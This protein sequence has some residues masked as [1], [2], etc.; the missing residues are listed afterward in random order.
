M[1]GYNNKYHVGIDGKGYI[2]SQ[3]RPG[4]FYY[5]KKV[6]PSFVNKVGSGDVA[7]RDSTFW[8]Y[9]ATTNWRNGSK[10]LRLDDPGKFWK[11]QDINITQLDEITLSRKLTLVGQTAAGTKIN[12]IESWRT[13][14]SWWNANY[15]YRQQITI[16]APASIQVPSGYPVK[17]TI[18]TSAL[19]TASKVRSDRNDWRVVYF[20]GS[21]WV[22]LKRDYISASV[23]YFSLQNAISAGATDTNY[24]VYYGYSSESTSA[25]PSTEADWNA[26]YALYGTTPDANSVAIYYGREGSGTSVNDD[27]SNSNTL[28]FGTAG[29]GNPAWATGGKFGRY[30]DF[31]SSN[32]GYLYASD[33]AS[34]DLGSFTV[35]GYFNLKSTGA[36]MDLFAKGQDGADEPFYQTY[37]HTS[38]KLAF[39]GG[40]GEAQGT[41]ALSTSAW[42]HIAISYD[43]S[44]IAKFYID[45]VLDNSVATA[46]GSLANNAKR[47]YIGAEQGSAGDGS[48]K[49][50]AYGNYYAT[51][52]RV[53]NVERTSFPYALVTTE[54]TLSY[55]SEITTQPPASS[56]DV[57]VGCSN[58]KLYKWDGVT[59]LTE[60]F[61]THRITWYDTVS[62]VDTNTVIG[63]YTGTEYA[64]AQ[65]FQVGSVNQK[66]KSIQAYL[67]KFLG[68]PGNITVR[69]ETNNA[70][71]PS[72]TL[73]D[74]NLSTSITAFTTTS[75]DWVTAT[76]T[77]SGSLTSATTYW[78]VLKMAAGSSGNYYTIGTD[79]SSPTYSAGNQAYS[80]NGGSTWTAE[81]TKDFMFRIN[82]EDTQINDLLITSIGGTR[83]MLIATG[84]ISSQSNGNARLYSFDGTTYSLEKVFG[85]STEAQITS[86]A[87]FNNKLYAG[88]GPQAR[89]YEGSNV[90]TWTLS[91]DIDIPQG[92]GYIYAIKEYNGKLYAGGGNPE[93]LYDKHYSGFWYV[94]DGTTWQSLY[95]FDFTTIRAFEFYDAY[96]FGTTYH[97]HIYVYDTSTL[98]PLF[99]FKDN[100]SYQ[101][102]ILGAQLF[103]DKIYFFLYPQSGT[104]ET[105]IGVW[106]FDRHGM[107]LAHTVSGVTGFTCAAVVNNTLFIGT[108]N[109]GNVYR[110]DAS[111]YTATGYV[112]SSYFDANLP[113]MN[114]LF[115]AVTIQHDPLATGQSISVYFKFKEDDSWTL[116]GTSST[117]DATSSELSF[118]SGTYGKKISLKLVL[119][120]SDTS[121]TPKIK[122]CVLKY[123]ILPTRKWMWTMKLIAK[124]DLKLLDGTTES[125]TPDQIRSNIETSQNSQK[126]IT[127]VD[128][129]GNSY[130]TLFSDI[131]QPS[132]VINQANVN[133]DEVA[134]TLIEA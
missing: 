32:K 46:F 16:T 121:A 49:T 84:D 71:V 38:G 105:N 21:T 87:E 13:S 30:I 77:N 25:Q 86:L 60:Q 108:G 51:M 115:N 34:L 14:Q 27:S 127:F 79:A 80:T 124:D 99:N 61:D 72:G 89:I 107:S 100:Y 93:F 111:A 110:L 73:A 59:T 7:Y 133:E 63:N 131:D 52:L 120:T 47:L 57:Y 35:E 58:G 134:I 74:S 17:V 68:T 126:L 116:L 94:F 92:P 117:V 109:D 102:S 37:I 39:T 98:N 22:D 88:V 106:I 83:K 44:N 11:S 54:P 114:K 76:F 53:S 118:P 132:W 6:A 85:T 29:G 28:T 97:G 66:V 19:Q 130:T 48:E 40:S 75:Y 125:Y 112:Q 113:S 78:L 90:S 104:S 10:Q 81:S 122:E 31:T 4:Q 8:Q 91:K 95:P 18:D 129:D 101:V 5:Q 9:W 96:L 1:A 23:T 12:A 123:S 2:L 15:G 50:W 82:G 24:Y 43:G 70:G 3:N 45:G 42:H 20:N 64:I 62:L 128:V 26:A 119:T 33:N 67:K 36:Q 55:G 103:D 69:I 65:S 41:N 56:A